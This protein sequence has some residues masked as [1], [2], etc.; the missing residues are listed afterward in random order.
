MSG[1]ASA[2]YLAGMVGDFQPPKRI[3]SSVLAPARDASVAAPRLVEWPDKPGWPARSPQWAIRRAI[4]WGDSAARGFGQ[5][6]DRC[7]CTNN[8]ALLSRR[9]GCLA[10]Q[11]CSSV[12]AG[13]VRVSMT[14]AVRP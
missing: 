2:T 6:P 3:R 14:P 4:P 1:S 9:P 7:S 8:G 10:S 12:A 13:T 11:S 5:V